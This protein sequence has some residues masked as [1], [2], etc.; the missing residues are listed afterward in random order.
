[1]SGIKKKSVARPLTRKEVEELVTR[2]EIIDIQQN[3]HGQWILFTT[4]FQ[5]EVT[6]RYLR[7]ESPTRIFRSHRLG[8][9]TIGRKRIERCVYRWCNHPSR[10]RV[11]RWRREDSP[12][13]NPSASREDE[14]R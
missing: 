1:M 14:E 8:P 2:P 7:G 5:D 6:L 12:C 3:E 9:E 11:E 10:A 13:L 4:K